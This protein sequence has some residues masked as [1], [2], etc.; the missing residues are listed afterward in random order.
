MIAISFLFEM[1]TREINCQIENQVSV[2]QTIVKDV[3][4]DWTSKDEIL[5][6]GN[7]PIK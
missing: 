5:T 4:D 2:S 1:R 3:D 7:G 6:F